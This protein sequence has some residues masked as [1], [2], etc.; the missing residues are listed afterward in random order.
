MAQDSRTR[1]APSRPPFVHLRLH[2][3]FSICD[4]IV[5]IPELAEALARDGHGACALTDESNLFAM[6]KF[7]RAA[8][9][10]DIKPI[11]GA[12]L[13][14]D[15]GGSSISRL[16]LLVRNQEGYLNLS[17]LLTDAQ[18]R[19]R[20]RGQRRVV[21]S[22][23]ALIERCGGLIA[24]SG[25]AAGDIG[26][27]LLNDRGELARKRFERW[28][29]CFGEDFYIELQRL[30]RERDEEYIHKAVDLAQR[31]SWA[32]VATNEVRFLGAEEYDT[33]LLR[34]CIQEA[35]TI[36]E[37]DRGRHSEQ[38][39]LRS[40]AE[41]AGLFADLP[42]ALEN[43]VEISHRCNF[44]VPLSK[45]QL[46][47][48]AAADGMSEN[49]LI[50]QNA[51]SGLDERL[52]H[53][54]GSDTSGIYL[55]RLRYELDI[56]T[57]VG[58]AGYFLIVAKFTRWAR[59]HDVPVGPGRGSGAGSLVA[60]SLGITD[61]DPIVHGLFFERFLNPERLEMPD[62]DIDFC[63]EGRDRVIDY[64]REHHGA[65]R[66]AQII[67]FGTMAARA[68]VRDTARVLGQPYGLADRIAK[69]IPGAPGGTLKEAL[70]EKGEFSSDE[71]RQ[72]YR[73]NDRARDI[74]EAA[75]KLEGLT[76]NAGRHAGGVV[77]AAHPLT[78]IMP[79]YAIEEG[80]TSLVTQF[81][82]NDVAQLGIVKFDFLGLRTLTI[83]DWAEKAINANRSGGEPPFSVSRL[84]LD[85][86]KTF[87]LLGRLEVTGVFQLES[88]G[89]KELLGRLKPDRF[90]DITALIAL[91]RPGPLSAQ[92]D[93]IYVE[94]RHGRE[95]VDY[96]HPRLEPI[97]RS[98]YGTLVYQEQVLQIAQEL[99]G[100]TAGRADILRKAMG[101]KIPE[102]MQQ[103]RVPFVEAVVKGGV[104]KNIAEEIFTQAADFSSYGF[105]K[106]HSAA[107]ALL[108]Y[109]TAWLKAHRPLE[110]LT[111]AM[112][113][114]AGNIDRLALYGAECRRLK[115]DL[116]APDIN[117]SGV[118]FEIH[119]REIV[120]GLKAVRGSGG[121][122]ARQVVEERNRG[123]PFESLEDFCFRVKVASIGRKAIESW[124]HAGAFDSI[125]DRRHLLMALLPDAISQAKRALDDLESGQK[126]LFGESDPFAGNSVQSPRTEEARVEPWTF[127]QALRLERQVVGQFLRSHPCDPWQQLLAD[128]QLSPGDWLDRIEAAQSN[129][130]KNIAKLEGALVGWAASRIA[131]R[132]GGRT[133]IFIELEDRERRLE[134]FVPPEM[135]EHEKSIRPNQMLF[136]LVRLDVGNREGRLRMRARLLL[137]F[138]EALGRL[139]TDLHFRLPLP[140][141]PEFR[142]SLR[143]LLSDKK[144]EKGPCTLRLTLADGRY[145]HPVTFGSAWKRAL[146]PALLLGLRALA[147]SDGEIKLNPWRTLLQTAPA[148]RHPGHQQ[149]PGQYRQPYDH[150]A[151][152]PDDY[153]TPDDIGNGFGDSADDDEYPY[154]AEERP[155]VK[156]ICES[157]DTSLVAG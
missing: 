130:R 47:S 24:L 117:R 36:N 113:V 91:F 6:V 67:T 99:A 1:A 48:F 10:R 148:R 25:A 11:L 128:N 8:L 60:W 15:D 70:A 28:R 111:A 61:L 18:E 92:A 76:R 107:Y 38:Q 3:E 96:L 93:R 75:Q 58:F 100:Y 123:G 46:P 131:R 101:K 71:L 39:Y 74:I 13:L 122:A 89:M 119:G 116:V 106:S 57:Q 157:E 19:P 80:D 2:S 68:V 59:E 40:P 54:D 14:I 85:D 141:P 35:V 52:A 140:Q 137:T 98:T 45:P 62:F 31:Y 16:A 115:I 69:A 79:L 152:P 133:L 22:M 151:P 127:E 86:S 43:S 136:A 153:G 105:N 97:L 50:E 42:S 56:I 7:Y 118:L 134:I 112:S 44:H 72:L 78:E 64:V 53:L 156:D 95:K 84:P 104:D 83:I 108:A 88:S 150:P 146:S 81:D 135:E 147:G 5:R 30:G 149:E 9:E 65:D 66:V 49:E 144:H 103:E 109:Q 29:Q 126:Q 77:I 143:R 12:D 114:E 73:D 82:M 121:E 23:Q 142:E 94:R 110:F 138:D 129:G 145:E 26:K 37:A 41:M 125:D 154:P 17:R 21:V 63:G 120:Y 33:H 90:E 124:I 34:C 102:I 4:S 87:E 32:V 51:Q 155:P 20:T 55:D 132:I 139:A 27:A